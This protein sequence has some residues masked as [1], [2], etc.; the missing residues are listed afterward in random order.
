[1]KPSSVL[2]AFLFVILISPAA[3]GSAQH[4][5]TGSGH[6]HTVPDHPFDDVERWSKIFDD[7]ERDEWQMPGKVVAALG[8]EPGSV[9]ADVGA[10]TGYFVMHLAP[11][12]AP[13]GR[14][15]AIDI[16]PN[17]VE[18]I[19]ERAAKGKLD[20]VEPTV[21]KPDDPGIPGGVA[22]RILVVDTY[23]HIRDRVDY[24]TRLKRSL[25][26]GGQVVIVDFYKR[27]LPVGPPT[28]HKM[29]RDHVIEEF[30]E[31]GY[32]LASEETFLPHQYFLF[33]APR[34]GVD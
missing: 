28:E 4:E 3:A 25:A 7:P 10:G 16:E 5:E 32:D 27:P 12:V 30:Q 9:V 8:L 24:L 14:V 23:H 34:Q 6:Q 17:M 29:A 21:G 11:A 2:A 13:G 1:M 33:F 31:A 22:D 20:G 19:R 18:H 15:L 26:E